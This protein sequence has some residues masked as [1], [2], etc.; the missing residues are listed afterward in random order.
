M[1]KKQDKFSYNS[2]ECS[3]DVISL[4]PHIMKENPVSDGWV[5]CLNYFYL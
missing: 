1:G 4:L 5:F 2:N 3:P